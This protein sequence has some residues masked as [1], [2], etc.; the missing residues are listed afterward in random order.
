MNKEEIY[1]IGAKNDPKTL[2]TLT[3]D[4]LSYLNKD[5]KICIEGFSYGSTGRAVDFQYGLGWKI[6]T[7][8][9]EKGMKYVEVS[10]GGIKK[11]ATSTGRIKKENMILPIFKRWG[12]EHDS[13]NVRDAFVIAQIARALNEEIELTKFQKEV[14]EVLKKWRK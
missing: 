7:T 12:F 1:A 11:F 9:Y 4:V 2:I 8:L 6:R 13:D 14:L 5:D 3:N 10:P